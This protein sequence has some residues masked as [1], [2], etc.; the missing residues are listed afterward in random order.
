[1]KASLV[2]KMG[3]QLT[4]TPQLQ[5]AIRLLQMST[6]DLQEEIQD[7]LES[8]PMLEKQDENEEGDNSAEEK[9]NTVDP[10]VSAQEVQAESNDETADWNEKIPN[11][12]E[13]DTSW[14]DVYQSSASNIPS[15][16][17]A[18]GEDWDFTSTTSA[19]SNLQDHLHWQLNLAT[20]NERDRAI[21]TAIIDSIGK[22]GYLRE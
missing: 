16:S 12:L 8:N 7:A 14:E 18:S 3:Q 10:Q 1:M 22:D 9:L 21:A 11:E 15:S 13:I 20:M 19:E 6:L 5:Q 17:A 2:L 4:M